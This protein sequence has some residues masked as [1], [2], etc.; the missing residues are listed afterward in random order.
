[1]QKR[2]GDDEGEE[3]DSSKTGRVTFISGP[4]V[5]FSNAGFGDWS[6]GSYSLSTLKFVV[7]FFWLEMV[8][9][10]L[11][12]WWVSLLEKHLPFVLGLM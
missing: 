4:T 9:G 8:A 7:F 3:G 6:K 12:G 5:C 2:G 10:G 11:Y 1:M